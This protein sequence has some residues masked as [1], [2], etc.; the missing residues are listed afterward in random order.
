MTTRSIT[1]VYSW[2]KSNPHP[3]QGGSWEGLCEQ[4]VNNAG[5]FTNAFSTATLELAH[6][7]KLYT[8]TQVPAG[9][10]PDGWLYHWAYIDATDHVDYGHVA[11][12]YSSGSALMAS[13]YVTQLLGDGVGLIHAAD[14]ATASGHHY[15]GASP[16]HGGQYLL[17]VP[18][19]LA[20][21]AKRYHTVV[22]GDTLASIAAADKTTWQ[23]LYALNVGVVGKD[24]DA[25]VPGEKLLLP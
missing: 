9:K 16:D 10:A 2:T 5:D 22:K 13:S 18:H 17:G 21:P 8:P 15:L 1:G 6:A 19:T 11:F 12:A 14:Y 4:Y 25:I 20:T 23:K 24:P 7:S 3:H